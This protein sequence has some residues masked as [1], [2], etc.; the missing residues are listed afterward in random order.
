MRTMTD[1]D[2]NLCMFAQVQGRVG[3]LPGAAAILG[4]LAARRVGG[5]RAAGLQGEAAHARAG[6]RA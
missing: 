2:A 6:H 3:G 4:G 5:R 1:V